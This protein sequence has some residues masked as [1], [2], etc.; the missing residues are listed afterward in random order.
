[1]KALSYYIGKFGKLKRAIV[2]GIKA[3]HKPILLLA[4]I[5]QFDTERIEAT[6]LGITAELVADFSGAPAVNKRIINLSVTG[7]I[8]NSEEHFRTVAFD[9]SIMDRWYYCKIIPGYI[10]R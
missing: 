6:R 9:D 3:P 7:I 4:I 10:Y 1:M 5:K 2:K 8:R